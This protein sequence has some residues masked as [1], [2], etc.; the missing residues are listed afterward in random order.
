M[1]GVFANIQIKHK[2]T[3]SYIILNSHIRNHSLFKVP[4]IL[5]LIYHYRSQTSI[6]KRE[7]QCYNS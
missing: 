3:N 5:Y 7:K 1:Y 6:V 2:Y 4:T